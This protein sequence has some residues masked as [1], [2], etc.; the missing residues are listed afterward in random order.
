[1]V[2]FPQQKKNS[3]SHR[4][5]IAASGHS[6]GL[7]SRSPH[8]AFLVVTVTDLCMAARF[9]TGG[10]DDAFTITSAKALKTSSG[11][12]W[13]MECEM[14]AKPATAVARVEGVQMNVCAACTKYGTVIKQLPGPK[15]P[16]RKSIAIAKPEPVVKQELIE[17]VRPDIG[18]LLRKHREALKLNQE[19]FA[20]K[21]Q[22]R[23]S[24]YNHYESGTTLPDITAARKLEHVLKTPLVVHVKIATAEAKKE[25][26]REM[27]MGDFLKKKK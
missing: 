3:D 1:V 24:T 6:L 26:A 21:L 22:I 2:I 16:V 15:A 20:A 17:Q 14:C 18:K 5:V 12:P 11:R 19:Q 27:T 10:D 25:P 8:K 9:K 13:R 4:Y 23:G 7:V